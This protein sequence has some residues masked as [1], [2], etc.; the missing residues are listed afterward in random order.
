MYPKVYENISKKSF[1]KY[2]EN[3]MRKDH[4]AVILFVTPN[5]L[6]YGKSM[7]TDDFSIVTDNE[8]L[9]AMVCTQMVGASLI[10]NVEDIDEYIG[11]AFPLASKDTVLQIDDFLKRHHDK[12][13]LAV[14]DAGVARSGF[15]S[16]YLDKKNGITRDWVKIAKN[17]YKSKHFFAI[18]SPRLT[19]FANE[20]LK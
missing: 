19:K 17:E 2:C 13:I 6:S 15:V 3:R 7:M 5:S 14:C 10:I 20:I 4:V 9:Q 11:E 12:H 1:I 18:T 8:T 16:W